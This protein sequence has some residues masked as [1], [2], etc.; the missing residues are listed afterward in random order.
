[1]PAERYRELIEQ[2]A[3]VL[4]RNDAAGRF[5]YVSGASVRIYGRRPEELLGHHPFE[6]VHAD[7]LDRVQRTVSEAI[8]RGEEGFEVTCRLIRPDGSCVWVQTIV[9]WDPGLRVG[10]GSVRDITARRELLEA[11]QQFEGAFEQSPIGMSLTSL[12]GTWLRVNQALCGMVG[13]SREDLLT[14]PFRELTHLDDQVA[15]ES[16]FAAV[17][18]GARQSYECEKRY[19]HADGHVVWVA[20]TASLVCDEHGEPLYLVEDAGHL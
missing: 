7:D 19:I 11:T 20:L 12:D 13:R 8:D 18:A 6:F 3:D 4:T 2:S 16:G 5:T 1:M 14:L 9:R 15:D 17:R 10:I